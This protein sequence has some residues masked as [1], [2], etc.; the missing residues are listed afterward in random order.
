MIKLEVKRLSYSSVALWNYCPRAW[1]LRY[2]YKYKT[3]SSIAQIFGT[4]M[5]KTIQS[6]LLENKELNL[7]S[8]Y[9]QNIF[10]KTMFE[11]PTR[12]RV[13]DA[14]EAIVLG[15]QIIDDPMTNGIFQT[16]K[17][18]AESQ[19]EHEFKFRVPKVRPPVIGFIDIIDNEGIPYDIKTSAWDWTY[20]RAMDEIQPDFYLTALEDEGIP[21]PN[22]KFTYII[23]KKHNSPTT[24]LIETERPHHRER[25]YD[26][27]SDMWNGVK[28]K[29]WESDCTREACKRC[30]FKNE[31]EKLKVWLV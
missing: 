24:Y 25:S 23:V 22:N 29:L 10:Y 5:H 14:T 2:E 7:F 3:P 30:E 17:V 20:E 11:R 8:N 28:S 27:I 19:I 21:S 6:S 12:A 9:F 18:K 13:V 15:Q 4:A 31:C 1:V 16:I 26:I